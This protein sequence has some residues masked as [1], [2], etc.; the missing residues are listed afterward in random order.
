MG[1]LNQDVVNRINSNR[2]LWVDGVPRKVVIT[3]SELKQSQNGSEYYKF[4]VRSI[5]SGKEVSLVDFK[6]FDLV[7]ANNDTIDDYTVFIAT[8]H[9]NGKRREY[10]DKN[11]G[12]T[13]QA[14]EW[15]I[16]WQIAGQSE[17]VPVAQ[18]AK[19]FS[20]PNPH[21]PHDEIRLEDIPFK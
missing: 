13:K 21:L 14:I 3:K 4:T 16:D 2:N 5:E 11:T 6:L 9:D 15:D 19:A 7:S 17:T 8:P 20:N 1:F 12:Q 10:E 18:S